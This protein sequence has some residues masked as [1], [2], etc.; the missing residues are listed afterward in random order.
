MACSEAW[1]ELSR[2]NFFLELR[3]CEL[4]RITLPRTPVNRPLEL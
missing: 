4:R 2:A 3:A 1:R